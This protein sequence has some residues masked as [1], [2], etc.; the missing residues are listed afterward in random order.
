MDPVLK[1]TD[2]DLI[3]TIV[4]EGRGEDVLKATREAGAHG[5][6]VVHGRGIGIHET[7]QILGV[8]IEPRKDLVLTVTPA[9]EVKGMLAAIVDSVDLNRP[10][11]GIAFVVPLKH[12]TG[13]PHLLEP[14]E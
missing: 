8:P 3:V 13:I 7:K 11:N 2:F 1:P 5:G 12:V 6:T 10:G 9:A 4:S 14:L